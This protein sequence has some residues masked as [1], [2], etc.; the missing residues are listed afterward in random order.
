MKNWEKPKNVKMPKTKLGKFY[1]F[2][3]Y[4]I[5]SVLGVGYFP[6][7]SGTAGSFV[8]LPIVFIIAYF[9]GLWGLLGLIL[10][11]MILGIISTKEVLKY[12]SHDPSIVVIDEVVGQSVTFLFVADRLQTNLKAWPIYIIGF[13]LF[14]LFDITKPQPAKWA[15]TKL[16]NAWGV[17]LDDVFAGLYA[18]IAL[19]VIK[20]FL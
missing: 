8:T 20:I 1:R 15:D 12:T 9:W 19:Y 5:A 4:A 18:G 7:A 17:M 2:L 3:C 16:L 6:V 10:L 14:R 11:T 13:C